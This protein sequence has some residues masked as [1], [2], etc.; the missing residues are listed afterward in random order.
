MLPNVTLH[1][2]ETK[3]VMNSE[4]QLSVPQLSQDCMV[5]KLGTVGKVG[6]VVPK[7]F[8][9]SSKEVPKKSQRSPKEVPKKSQRS[10]KEVPN[11]SQQSP[12]K[13]PMSCSKQW[14]VIGSN[15]W[16]VL[17]SKNKRCVSE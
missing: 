17:C 14:L 3:T 6:K 13:V 1:C 7:K 15:Q 10:P 9:R 5:G 4:S 12:Q 11:K 16:L 2:K 8:Q